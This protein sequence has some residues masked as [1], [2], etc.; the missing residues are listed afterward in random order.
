MR[1]P[2]RL[3]TVY[4]GGQ[5]QW[6][7]AFHRITGVAVFLF[8]LAHIVDTALVGFGPEL[9]NR[10]VAVYHNPIIRLMEIA[11]AG[12]VLFH[13]LNGLKII[14]ID[15]FPK[16]SDR[17]KELFGIVVGLYIILIVPA[18]YFMGRGFFRSL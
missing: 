3:G 2:E 4:R 12:L 13:A 10:V 9:Y 14:A 17:H 16:L 1:V 5:G 18:L 7:W 6:S 15:F 11:L 8:L